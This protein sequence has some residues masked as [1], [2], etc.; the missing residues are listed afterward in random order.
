M[1]RVLTLDDLLTLWKSSN[2]SNFSSKQSGYQ[3]CVHAMADGFEIDNNTDEEDDGL[4]LYCKTKA[5]HLGKNRNG[6]FISLQSAQKAIKHLAY[7]PVLAK[8]YDFSDN[9]EEEDLDF[10]SHEIEIDNDGN[11]VYIEQ[12]VGS[13]TNDIPII[14]YDT[15]AE[16]DFII[17]D[18]IEKKGGTKVSVEL[19][20]NEL[21]WNT[22][23]NALSLDDFEVQG[24]TLLGRYM[25]SNMYG[26]QVEEGME[27]AKLEIED[28][29]EDNNSVVKF[30][31]GKNDNERL[32]E[33]LDR[34]NNTLSNLSINNLVGKEE[35][36]MGDENKFEGTAESQNDGVVTMD[37]N[38]DG[39]ENTVNME[40]ENADNTAESADATEPTAE[41][42]EDS[43]SDEGT[44]DDNAVS[45]NEATD[46][47]EDAEDSGENFESAENAD[48]ETFE[49]DNAETV[50]TTDTATTD[51]PEKF[52]VTFELSH[53]DLRATLFDLLWATY[54]DN[55]YCIVSV[56]DNYFVAEDWDAMNTYY[57]FGYEKNESSVS[58]T[59]D[60]VQVYAEYL[61]AAE[62]DALDLMRTTYDGLQ[63]EVNAYKAKEA[64]QEKFEKVVNNSDYSVIKD[65]EEFNSLVK[66][67]DKY[68]VEEFCVKADLLLAKYV[69]STST[70]AAKKNETPKTK[71]LN[72]FS[73]EQRESKKNKP[74]G[75]IFE[76]FFNK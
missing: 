58:L 17:A 21:S 50:E 5:F 9:D 23:I 1:K 20:I 66:D 68:T 64:T 75:G 18:I 40:N 59:G 22:E 12:Q 2:F 48:A 28:F 43:E 53:E 63:N 74:Y 4:I 49:T 60:M 46:N 38:A 71:Y 25:D 62:K 24:I 41:F 6:S 35:N 70:F 61:T 37:E 56:Y 47:T 16:K 51:A 3:L 72:L 36:L 7:K 65:T 14:I 67:M 27:G 11:L 33:T 13:F 29:K 8:I 44:P 26:V 57:K 76:D 15:E 45:E 69:K 42:T 34:L 54:P 19:L 31:S 39:V 32:I 73:G 52:S 10:T 30:C 55:F